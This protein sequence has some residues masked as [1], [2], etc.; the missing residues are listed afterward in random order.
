MHVIGWSRTEDAESKPSWVMFSKLQSLEIVHRV[1]HTLTRPCYGVFIRVRVW[2]ASLGSHMDCGLSFDH[3][4]WN[5]YCR[6]FTRRQQTLGC[7][8]AVDLLLTTDIRQVVDSFHVQS[9]AEGHYKGHH[10]QRGTYF[11]YE[12][13]WGCKCRFRCTCR[14]KDAPSGY[15][16]RIRNMR[17]HI[18]V[19]RVQ[20]WWGSTC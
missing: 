10:Q 12:G 3:H 9:R 20:L 7:W 5:M 15:Y 17:G 14:G 19:E 16:K 1:S 8:H 11:P 2:N 4:G 6:L 18:R 13:V